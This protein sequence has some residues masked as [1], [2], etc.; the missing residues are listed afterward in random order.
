MAGVPLYVVG[1]ALGHRTL[2]MTA[3]YSHLA[4]DSHRAAFEAVAQTGKKT[5]NALQ[6]VNLEEK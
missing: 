4:L 5:G 3:R 2:V 1:K 6:A